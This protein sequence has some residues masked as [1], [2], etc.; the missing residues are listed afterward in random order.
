MPLVR[1]GVPA[2]VLLVV[3]ALPAAPAAAGSGSWGWPLAGPH[4][5]SRP[6]A[7]PASRYG[8]GHRGVDLPAPP[9]AAVRAA[10]AG[11]VTYAGLLAGRG[12]VVVSHGALR[13]TYEPVTAVVRVGQAVALGEVIGHLAAGHLGCPAAVCLH[14][15]L[16]RGEQY[17]DPVRLVERGPVRLLPVPG[18]EAATPLINAEVRHLPPPAEASESGVDQPDALAPGPV[19]EVD[20]PRWSL[21]AAEAPLGAAAVAALVLGVGLLARPRPHPPG[22][23]PGGAAG[24]S[25]S[26]DVPEEAVGGDAQVLDLDQARARRPAA[27]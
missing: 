9:G 24:R 20:E 19:P 12:V 11:R 21:Q 15:G 16:R 6:F 4:S 26:P 3:G 25:V 2:L 18:A 7:P 8:A 23:A 13:T 27:S 22:P 10:A 5:V 1:A 17:L 14:W